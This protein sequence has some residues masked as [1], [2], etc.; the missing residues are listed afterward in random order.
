MLV[1]EKLALK[2]VVH[3]C[4]NV[5]FTWPDPSDCLADFQTLLLSVLYSKEIVIKY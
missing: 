5:L 4:Q 2:L 3:R 1:K